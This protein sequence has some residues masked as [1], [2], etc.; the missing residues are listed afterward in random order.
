MNLSFPVQEIFNWGMILPMDKKDY[1]LNLSCAD[2]VGIVAAVTGAMAGMGLFLLELSQFSDPS[3]QQFFMRIH[4]ETTKEISEDEILEHLGLVAKRFEMSYT[5]HDTDF[6][7]KV[8]LMVSKHSHCLNDLLHRWSNGTLPVEIT[9]VVSN[10]E[11]LQLM[12]SWYKVPFHHM[13]ITPDNKLE[14]EQNLL[15]LIEQEGVDLVVL[16]RYMQILTDGLC[17]KMS[18]RI[19][20]IHHSFLPSFKGAKPYHQ[21]YDR[22][23]KIIGATAHYVTA[24]L[25]EGPIIDQEV[26]RVRHDQLPKELV[27]LGQDVECQVLARAVK[28]HCEQRVILNGNK[29]VVFN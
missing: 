8:I 15:R 24:D 10:H 1:V 28:W 6:R 21:A 19:I 11:D 17:Q 9:A 2:Q 16:A 20:N 26:A 5:L 4:F 29:T 12:A 25:D 22:G 27:R 18:G 14:Q 23:V 13:P 7:P 3:T